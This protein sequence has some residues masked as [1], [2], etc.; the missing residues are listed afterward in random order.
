M[1]TALPYIIDFIQMFLTGLVTWIFARRKNAAEADS[2]ELDNV[3]KAI[4]IWRNLA[5]DLEAKIADMRLEIEELKR[6]QA[7]PTCPNIKKS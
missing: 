6:Q 4:A 7:C 1:D 5:K 2:M 3:D